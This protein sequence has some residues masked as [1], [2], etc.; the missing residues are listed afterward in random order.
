[1]GKIGPMTSFLEKER[2]PESDGVLEEANYQL[3]TWLAVQ[4][5]PLVGDGVIWEEMKKGEYPLS[6]RGATPTG[7]VIAH[8]SLEV[9][10][11]VTRTGPFWKRLTEKKPYVAFVLGTDEGNLSVNHVR[12]GEW[13]LNGRHIAKFRVLFSQN[14]NGLIFEGVE[15][16]RYSEKSTNGR[17][18][19]KVGPARANLILGASVEA[20]D[21]LV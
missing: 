16:Y 6:I 10:E 12:E 9:V 8:A 17:A 21:G 1:M 15:A 18:W 3:G 2:R 7:P 13:Y 5:M 14:P 4:L 20:M 19:V 11:K